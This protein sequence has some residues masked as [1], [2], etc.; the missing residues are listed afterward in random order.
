MTHA[1]TFEIIPAI[2]LRGGQV[3]RLRQGDFDRETTYGS[4]P[5]GVAI[6]CADAGVRWLHVVDLDGARSGAPMN[7]AVVRAIVTAV[8]ERLSVEVAGGLRTPATVRACLDAGAARAVIGTAAVHD[9][10]SMAHLIAMHGSE[11]IAVALDVRDGL[12]VGDGWVPGARGTPA[13]AALKA[14]TALGVATFEVTAIDRD[15]GME[16]P[17]LP[18]YRRLVGL[19][20]GA[21]TAS[22][23]IRSIEDLRAVRDAGCVGAIVGRA[24]LDGS[25]DLVEAVAA[26]GPG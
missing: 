19:G 2:D 18:L 25:L 24:F 14:L 3:V 22:G 15:G 16:G 10:G 1:T 13:D 20:G 11:R 9:P 4:D 21:I 5:V 23:G 8:G 17:D 12:A 7:D 26:L 6:R